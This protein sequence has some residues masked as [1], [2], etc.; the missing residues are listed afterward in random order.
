MTSA[1]ETVVA[2][3]KAEE[4]RKT[5]LNRE[6]EGLVSAGTAEVPDKLFHDLRR[7][8]ARNMVR[9]GVPECV[10]ANELIHATR[11]CVRIVPE[12]SAT[13]GHERAQRLNGPLG[14]S[15]IW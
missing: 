12:L 10:A 9:A 2:Q 4:E 8:A 13:I 15:L 14:K 6:L 1:L 3:I 5:V 7:T 11:C